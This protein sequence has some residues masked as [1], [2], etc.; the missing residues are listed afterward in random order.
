VSPRG[1]PIVTHDI[2]RAGPMLCVLHEPASTDAPCIPTKWPH[3]ALVVVKKCCT[4]RCGLT[5]CSSTL[6]CG[7]NGEGAGEGHDDLSD[8]DIDEAER[9]RRAVSKAAVA[10]SALGGRDRDGLPL[11][12]DMDNYDDESGGSYFLCASRTLVRQYAT[13]EFA[14]TITFQWTN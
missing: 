5:S 1:L 12:L 6:C 4:L 3:C 8:E 7:R 13:T 2:R 10:A 11:E 14:S 9:M